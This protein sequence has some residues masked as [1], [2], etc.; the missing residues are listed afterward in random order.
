MTIRLANL[1][2]RSVLLS[3]DR[4][5]DVEKRSK[6]RFTADPTNLMRHWDDLAQWGAG[7]SDGDFDA[8]FD[9][10]NLG[11]PVPRP[12]KVFAVGLNYQ[13]HAKEANLPPPKQPMIFT[14]FPNCL[15]GP[16]AD[17]VL[18]SDFVD[19]EVELVVVIG[20]GGRRIAEGKALEHVAGYCVG[21]D[22]SDRM[23]QFSDVPPQF[24]MSKSIDTFGPVG[25][26]VVSLD[27]FKNPNDL[28]LTCMVGDQRMQHSRTSDMIYGVPTII[29]H[30][31]A[32]CTLEPGDLIFT[33]TPDGVGSGQNPR[34]Y[35]KAGEVITST[36]EG[37]G[38]IVNRCVVG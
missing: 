27:A 12:A 24:S 7:L 19:W 34:R 17:V 31:S 3:G 28:E 22:V 15:C 5:L 8:P 35:L 38:T 16:R 21:Q 20:R 4:C 14:K 33:G 1:A 25:P 13:S 2:G 30:L 36:I 26:A 29:A 11:A 9:A 6:G 18:S 32:W 10:K 37:I 23:M